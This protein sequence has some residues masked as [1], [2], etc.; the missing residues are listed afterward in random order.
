MNIIMRVVA[1]VTA[2]ASLS[3]SSVAVMFAPPDSADPPVIPGDATVLQVEQEE[4][5]GTIG[6]AIS[7]Y[8]TSADLLARRRQHTIAP[9]L[10]E[11]GSLFP[12]VEATAP[13]PPTPEPAPN[14]VIINL[15]DARAD[16]MEVLPNVERWFG[17]QG[18]TFE[19]AYVTT[20]SCCPSRATLMTGQLVHNN[21]QVDQTTPL[22]DES[23]SIQRYLSDSGY[24]TGHT[25]KL[26]LIHI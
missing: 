7:P 18:V 3:V 14:I 2:V 4:F 1:M 11:R 25:G 9:P 26:S 20:P 10:G 5:A 21:G 17:D 8:A 24:F 15:D 6:H 16:V 19:N 23:T 12:R 22:T 13:T